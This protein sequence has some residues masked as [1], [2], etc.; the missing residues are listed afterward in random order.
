MHHCIIQPYFLFSGKR[1]CERITPIGYRL[2]RIKDTFKL[3]VSKEC[4]KSLQLLKEDYFYICFSRTSSS[5][6]S[7]PQ[8]LLKGFFSFSSSS[9]A[10]LAVN[11]E[12]QVAFFLADARHSDTAWT[13]LF[14]CGGVHEYRHLFVR[15]PAESP[16]LNSYQFAQLSHTFLDVMLCFVIYYYLYKIVISVLFQNFDKMCSRSTSSAS[17][18]KFLRKQLSK[19][20]QLKTKNTTIVQSSAENHVYFFLTI[21]SARTSIGKIAF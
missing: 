8:R 12:R 1:K 19:R 17:K 13:L 20:H 9:I 6:R 4:E 18:I 3:D 2:S 5:W 16:F 10:T 15:H 14:D 7:I 11:K 21:L